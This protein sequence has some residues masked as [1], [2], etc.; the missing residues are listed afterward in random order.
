MEPKPYSPIIAFCEEWLEKHGDTPVGVGWPR[1]DADTRYRVM[2]ELIR[3]SPSPVTLLDFG[4]GASHLYEYILR[5]KFDRIL[6]SGLDL[7]PRFLELSREKF[8]SVSY[9]DVD[10]LDPHS[11]PLPEFDYVVMNGVFNYRGRLSQDEMFEYLCELVRRVSGRG[12]VGVAFNVMSKQVDWEREE[13]FH[14]PVD[15]LLS[16]LSREVSR[17]VV[18]RHDYGLY[19][20]TAYVYMSPS[21]PEQAGTKRL[22]DGRRST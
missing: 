3:P 10:V 5:H 15:R 14:L 17:H 21:A 8:P 20:Y 2:L 11:I 6:Y 22:V 19:E 18:V 7:S 1:G 16:F 13:L 9:Y 12:R 4:C